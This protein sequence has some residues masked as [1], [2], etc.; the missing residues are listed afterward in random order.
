[1]SIQESVSAAI[2]AA[3]CDEKDYAASYI[4]E[5]KKFCR[6]ASLVFEIGAYTGLDIPAIHRLWPD[7]EIHCF[8]PM[9]EA[10]SSLARFSSE[11]IVCNRVALTNVKGPV[12]FYQV[13]D[14][15]VT[16]QSRRSVWFKTAGSLLRAGAQI[17]SAGPTLV[18]VAIPASGTTLDEYCHPM[19]LKPDILLIDTQGSEYQI[20]EGGTETLKT[21]K[22]ILCEWSKLELYK[23]QKMLEDIER[24]LGAAGFSKKFEVNQWSNFHGDAI[25]AKV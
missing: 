21:V 10:F 23:G 6:E 7:A 13:N 24:L 17:C 11:H 1:M 5:V 12:T 15:A 2:A 4:S 19:G 18:E 25:F 14:S 20:F 16:D 22:A 9:P 8:E 3:A